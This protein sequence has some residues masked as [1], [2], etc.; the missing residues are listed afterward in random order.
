MN[1]SFFHNSVKS[2]FNRNKIV[3][4]TL[5]D[6]SRTFDPPSIK[7]E[8]VNFFH[9]ILND[10]SSTYPG[11][12]HLAQFITKRISDIQKASLTAR[13]SSSEVQAA[14]FSIHPNKAP[15][16]DGF[17]GYFYRKMWHI[18]GEDLVQAIQ[19]FFETGHLLREINHSA[20]SLVPKI[21][22]PSKM[23]DYRPIACCNTIYKCIS[24]IL[25]KRI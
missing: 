3:S 1:T 16:P 23:N 25:A 10:N 2:R 5:E 12:N 8:A 22:N 15:G 21:P 14:F 17:N 6:G 19:F 13:V 20:I 18:V 7:V 11:R 24:K 4:L 9:K